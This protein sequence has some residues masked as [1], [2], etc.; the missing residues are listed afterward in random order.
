VDVIPCCIPDKYV[1]SGDIECLGRSEP[2]RFIYI[3]S[4]T[5]W[6]CFEEAVRMYSELKAPKFLI[7]YT[8]N[9]DEANKILK[10]YLVDC[11]AKEAKKA[12][13]IYGLRCSDFGFVLRQNHIVNHVASPVKFLEYVSQ[14]VVPICTPFVGDY[15]SDFAG[16]TYAVSDVG[17]SLCC[18]KL[19]TLRC[20]EIKSALV[21]KSNDYTWE[22][23]SQ[24]F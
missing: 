10:K 12:D 4:I 14:G 3:G 6:Q 19:V 15:S 5:K 9:F 21:L 16:L 17:A 7:V 20:P 24:L 22:K 18:D 1:Y 23:F 11:C 8:P 2:L 13:V